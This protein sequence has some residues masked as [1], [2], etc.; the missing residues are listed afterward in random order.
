MEILQWPKSAKV[1]ETCYHGALDG[2]GKVH[3]LTINEYCARD[4]RHSLP[5][6]GGPEAGSL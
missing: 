4:S 1:L 2:H 5:N 6:S 3:C